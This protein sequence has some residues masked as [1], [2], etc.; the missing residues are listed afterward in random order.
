MSRFQLVVHDT[1]VY[2]TLD[3]VNGNW[4]ANN[5][6]IFLIV[7]NSS[8]G[9]STLTI[10]IPAGVDED[11]TAPSRTYVLSNNVTYLTGY[12]PVNVYGPQLLINISTASVNGQPFDFR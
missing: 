12:F 7:R 4:V 10:A 6:S 1:A 5:G 2:P 9:A 8:G 11:L 3:N